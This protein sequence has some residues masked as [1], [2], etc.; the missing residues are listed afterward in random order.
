M[1]V[2]VSMACYRI[3]DDLLYDMAMDQVDAKTRT[4]VD[5]LAMR[6]GM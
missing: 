3:S 2:I 4:T 1:F 5:G 6:C